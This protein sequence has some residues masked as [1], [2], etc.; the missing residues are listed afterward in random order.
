MSLF[1]FAL[2]DE[3][4]MDES[5]KRAILAQLAAQGEFKVFTDPA[6][7]PTGFHF[8]VLELENDPSLTT[9]SD[10]EV[11]EARQRVCNLGYLRTPF[12][13]INGKVGYKCPSERT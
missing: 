13:Q 12:I 5:T 11:Y 1:R 8:K 6:A 10:P 9:L 3:S 7:S 4:G 2:A